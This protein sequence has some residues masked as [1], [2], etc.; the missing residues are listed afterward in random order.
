LSRTRSFSFFA[1]FENTVI[2]SIN[3]SGF[4]YYVKPPPAYSSGVWGLSGIPA[5]EYA[6]NGKKAGKPTLLTAKNGGCLAFPA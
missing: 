4:P 3:I 2:L 1:G 6:E 5:A